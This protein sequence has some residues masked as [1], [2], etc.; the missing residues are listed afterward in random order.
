MFF[1]TMCS[2]T[3]SLIFIWV[4]KCVCVYT[5]IQWTTL[6]IAYV[7]RLSTHHKLQR[8]KHFRNFVNFYHFLSKV[9]VFCT[10]CIGRASLIFIWEGICVHT[11]ILMDYSFHYLKRP[12]THH[13]IL[14]RKHSSKTRPP[15]VYTLSYKSWP[16]KIQPVSI[17]PFLL[18]FC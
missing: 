13:R 16:H 5:C 6:F 8:R 11:C 14:R 12:S 10:M 7:K 9:D 1:G 4:S 18:H 2:S 15:P 17:T 3:A